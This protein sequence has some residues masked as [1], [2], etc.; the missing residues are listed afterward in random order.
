MRS[1]SLSVIV[2]GLNEAAT[3]HRCLN[4][5]N[6][7]LRKAGSSTA[8]SEIIFVDAGSTD[9]SVTIA[10]ELADSVIVFEGRASAAAARQA[11]FREAEGRLV[12]FLD[13][14]MD[15]DAAWLPAALEHLRKDEHAAGI[16]G[17]RCD[18]AADGT[19]R[20]NVYGVRSLRRASHFGGAVLLRRT[21]VEAIGGYDPAMPNAE[22]PD[23]YARLLRAGHYV[24]EVPLPFVTHHLDKQPGLSQRIAR[25]W[26]T[27]GFWR[28][29]G[30]AVQNGYVSGFAQVYP[31][32][33]VASGAHAL[34][35]TAAV[36]YGW[37]GALAVEGVAIA[38]FAW[39]GRVRELLLAVFRW[40]SL[41][42]HFQWLLGRR[43]A[44][45]PPAWH[46][47]P[48]ERTAK[49]R[50]APQAQGLV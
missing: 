3:L 41:P 24:L 13:G 1:V 30:S 16:I 49:S 43:R 21:P 6:D 40:V 45:I 25:A 27:R 48:G 15:L 34:A 11:G 20:D 14:D 23:L 26:D 12:L 9:E 42:V 39:R 44:P 5:V 36:P 31:R 47:I 35:L 38:S 8:I 2:I 29:F 46:C 50:Q 10:R 33:V 17:I 28:S 37:S 7:A 4:S 19:V 22:E 18:R 32:F